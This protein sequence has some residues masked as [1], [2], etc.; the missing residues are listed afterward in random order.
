MK[1]IVY[2][3]HPISGDI[4]ANL[5]DLAR[6]LK[7]INTNSH[8]EMYIQ[9]SKNQGVFDQFFNF[10]D[11]LPCAPYYADI[12]SLDDNNPLE[13]KR[14]IEN[15]TA[16]I[17]TGIFDELWLT[18]KKISFGMNEEVKLFRSLGKTIIDYT[19]KF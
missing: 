7:I 10:H 2:I 16:L 5:K 13:R 1:K 12:I 19:N 15:D 14:G 11:I 4:D 17:M 6:I 3:A 9:T 8:P 18:G